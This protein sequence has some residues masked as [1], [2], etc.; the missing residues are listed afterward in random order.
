M[1]DGTKI[2]WTD[3][4]WNP[5]TGC[6]V[7]SPGCTNCYAMK[8]AG[9]RLT[10]HPSREGL[11]RNTKAGPVW[12]GAVRFNP[13]WLDEPLRWKKPR[14][15]FVCAHGDLFA[16]GVPDEW[17]DQIFAV[18]ALAPQHTFQVLTKRPE[19]MRQYLR[20]GELLDRLMSAACRIHSADGADWS[21]DI[22]CGHD[23]GLP[24]PNVWLGIS[25]EDQK[26]ADERIPI[27]LDTPAA[28]R[29]ISGEPLL[30]D[31]NWKRWLPTRRKAFRPGGE[32][33]LAP[34]YYMTKCEHCQWTGSSELCD[35]IN[36]GDDAD[37]ACPS[38]HN[39]ILGDELPAL[40]WIVA[41]GE[42]GRGARPMH[43]A[44]ARSLRDQCFA[45]GVPFHF[46]QWGNWTDLSDIEPKPTCVEERIFTT[47]GEVI[48]VGVDYGRKGMVDPEWRERGAAWMGRCSKSY[49]GRLL[50]GIEHNGFPEARR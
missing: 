48:G 28:V 16:E 10:H 5:I 40:D 3:A 37:V 9:T 4:T 34:H 44:W 29:W 11:T 14:M 45:A 25:A 42:S 17:I 35:L 12:T 31:I 21:A 46:K 6:S 41:G 23:R 36:Y 47:T 18:M 33:F 27:L 39:L 1:A 32:P 15:I 2:E 22:H 26:R 24:L 7:V 43:P 8:L 38:C 19:R 20:D 49:A 30:G 13:Q 50:D